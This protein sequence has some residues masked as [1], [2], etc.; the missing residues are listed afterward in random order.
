MS[1]SIAFWPSAEGNRGIG[2]DQKP[3]GESNP[4]HFASGSNARLVENTCPQTLGARKTAAE[5]PPRQRLVLFRDNR[6]AKLMQKIHTLT[7]N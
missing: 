4:A 5:R 1:R 7:D 2:S 3:R 6:P